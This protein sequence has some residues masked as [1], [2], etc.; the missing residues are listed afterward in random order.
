MKYKFAV[1]TAI[2]L[3]VAAY[4]FCDIKLPLNSGQEKT[5]VI[6]KNKIADAQTKNSASSQSLSI[7]YVE[8]ADKHR[9]VSKEL[10]LLC[11][12]KEGSKVLNNIDANTVVDVLDAAKTDDDEL[13]L[14]VQI[15]VYDSPS[16]FKGWIKEK[17][18]EPVTQGNL[19]ARTNIT[20]KA[21]TTVWEVYADTSQISSQN[22]RKLECDT[23]GRI[24]KKENGYVWVSCPGGSGFW[25]KEESADKSLSQ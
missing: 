22:E 10:K 15:P 2:L 6:Q 21:G 23:P 14:Q 8:Y 3:V 9:F 5:V 20:I 1:V 25:I 11:L 19:Q 7:N 16:N 18:T 12:P 17:D 4:I 13:W 24:E